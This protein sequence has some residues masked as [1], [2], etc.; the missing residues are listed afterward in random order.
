MEVLFEDGAGRQAKEK[1]DADDHY[2]HVVH[3]PE[4][5]DEIGDDI[6]G[7]GEVEYQARWDKPCSEGEAAVAHESERE[8]DL[9]AKGQAGYPFYQAF[10]LEIG[11]APRSDREE[12]NPQEAKE[13]CDSDEQ[14][15]EHFE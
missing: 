6:D 14:P 11:P 4:H 2:D 13:H 1:A 3:I 8:A 15:L 10:W 12:T 9:A 5:W 7:H